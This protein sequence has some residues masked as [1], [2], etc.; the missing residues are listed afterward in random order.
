MNRIILS[1][2]F[3][4][5]LLQAS[6]QKVYF[7]YLQNESDQPFFVRVN[8]KIYNSSGKGYLILS[9]LR[10]STQTI[11][12]GFPGNKWPEQKFE[13][14]MGAK[15]HG[16]M[17]KNF[18][19]K[20]WGLFDLQTLSVQMAL[21]KEIVSGNPVTKTEV[22]KFTE[23]L[24]KA[25]DDSTLKQKLPE[26]KKPEIITKQEEKK[27]DPVA[28]VQ[29]NP[30]NKMEEKKNNET[31]KKPEEKKKEPEKNELIES[32]ALKVSEIDSAK[33]D[34]YK[35]SVVTRKSESSA[36]EG[37]ELIFIDQYNDGT[38]DT[39]GIL[40]PNPKPILKKEKSQPAEQKK[41]LEVKTDTLKL[42]ADH[43]VADERDS[44]RHRDTVVKRGSKNNCTIT[45]GENDFMELRKKMASAMNDDGMLDEAR[46]FFKLTC[47]STA[48]IKNL[49]FLFLN[50]E[51]KYKFFDIAYTV[52]SDAEKFGSLQSEL[53]DKYY[54][55]RFKVMLRN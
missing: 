53:K 49:S 20:G 41:F 16:Y 52:V 6:S 15:D 46:K 31:I 35:K 2:V 27:P 21:V 39:I 33:S 11:N 9:K 50:D 13:V 51:G 43:A 12:I 8:D 44:T 18:G 38:K 7:I 3:S 5:L 1:L 24:A 42:A 48:Q 28:V 36:T 45:A 14:K 30:V 10:D 55:N 22:S 26:E 25:V 47:F 17:L 32:S 34:R 40:I 4:I 37:L 23:I 19:E 54:I 29:Q